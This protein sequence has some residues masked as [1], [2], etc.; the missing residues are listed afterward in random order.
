[1]TEQDTLRNALVT[2]SKQEFIEKFGE[3]KYDECWRKTFD[4]KPSDL[5]DIKKV[6]P[7]N[8]RAIETIID[9]GSQKVAEETDK[10]FQLLDDALRTK[11]EIAIKYLNIYLETHPD[12]YLFILNKIK[13]GKPNGDTR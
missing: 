11:P 13:P 12:E 10:S 9:S 2:H 8:F 6:S 3:E 7:D 5:L 4:P 1:M